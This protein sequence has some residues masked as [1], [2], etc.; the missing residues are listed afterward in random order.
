V[1]DISE[2]NP[3]NYKTNPAI[4]RNLQTLFMRLN[5]LQ[6]AFGSTFHITSGLRSDAQQAEL[7]AAGKTTAIHSKHLAG[8]AAD[9]LDADGK[10]AEWCK[11]NL[12]VLARIG[13]W[14]EDF[15]HTHGWVHFQIM[16]P[17]SGKRVFIP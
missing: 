14:C 7:I 15:G 11:L 8:A 2:L 9:I 16:A 12:D 1:K 5:E 6:D 3:K 4:D 10:L 17:G 13:F